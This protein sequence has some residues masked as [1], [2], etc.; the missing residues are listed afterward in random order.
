MKKL[1]LMVPV[2][3][4][5]FMLAVPGQALE[6]DDGDEL[7]I[8]NTTI[9]PVTRWRVDVSDGAE[10]TVK[11]D[12]VV[13]RA[14]VVSDGGLIVVQGDSNL[15]PNG[16]VTARRIRASDEGVLCATGNIMTTPTPGRFFCSDEGDILQKCD[17]V[18]LTGSSL[19]P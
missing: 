13:N 7:T 5:G 9:D 19:C 1:A 8:L 3:A 14:M 2:A 16:N 4:V 17:P 10:L 11:D 6:L 15:N 12:I 18:M